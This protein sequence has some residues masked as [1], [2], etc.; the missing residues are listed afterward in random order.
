MNNKRN[1]P[2]IILDILLAISNANNHI[3]VTHILRKANISHET[4]KKYSKELES[5]D[6]IKITEIKKQFFY[7][8][9]SK[10]YQ[11]ISKLKPLREF[12][13]SFNL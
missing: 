2:E 9:T 12:M 10:G 4:F 11:Q 13:K 5:K 6:Y 7:S 1:K 3:K 8:L